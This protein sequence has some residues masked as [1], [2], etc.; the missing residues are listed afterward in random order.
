MPDIVSVQII[1]KQLLW[2]RY[3]CKDLL[4]EN[5][6]SQ[7][8]FDRGIWST[9]DKQVR[10][11]AVDDNDVYVVTGMV[12]NKGLL[13]HRLRQDQH[14]CALLQVNLGLS[15][16]R[17]HRTYRHSDGHRATKRHRQPY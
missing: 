9:L 5:H 15:R 10:Q 2:D 17:H 3:L 1:L 11:W 12:L 4:W 6:V 16:A 13:H 7:W 8:D 14:S